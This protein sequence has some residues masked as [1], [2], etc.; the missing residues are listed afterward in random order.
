[1][2]PGAFVSC[3]SHLCAESRQPPGG[4]AVETGHC[5][6]RGSTLTM[7]R[8]CNHE[9]RRRFWGNGAQGRLRGGLQGRE[10]QRPGTEGT[11]L[12]KALLSAQPLSSSCLSVLS[13]PIYACPAGGPPTNVGQT[14][15]RGLVLL[16]LRALAQ[17]NGRQTDWGP[18]RLRLDP[19]LSQQL[20]AA[21]ARLRSPQ[22]EFAHFI[23]YT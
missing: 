19:R 1:M 2:V 11:V 13:C 18:A 22:C 16:P 8:T 4:P 20:P 15:F 6:T 14:P 17:D 10:Q 7:A 5:L 9:S 3:H 21:Y 12:M 23:R